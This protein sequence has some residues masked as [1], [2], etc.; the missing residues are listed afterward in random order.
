MEEGWLGFEAGDP[1]FMF[2]R[3]KEPFSFEERAA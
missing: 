1:R 3:M 2:G